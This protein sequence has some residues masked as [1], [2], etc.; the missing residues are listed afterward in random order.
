MAT[1]VDQASNGTPFF[2]IFN[3]SWS[4]PSAITTALAGGLVF[5]SYDSNSNIFLAL[6]QDTSGNPIF[7]TYNGAWTTPTEIPGSSP[8]TNVI[9]SAFDNN[10][11]IFLATWQDEATLKPFYATYNY[12]TD[13]WSTP[14]PID[15]AQGN[16]ATICS[17]DPVNAKFLAAWQ[18]QSLNIHYGIYDYPSNTW[19]RP[20]TK[21]PATIPGSGMTSS[22]EVAIFNSC[23]TATGRF[24]LGWQDASHFPFYDTYSL[25]APAPTTTTV[26]SEPNPSKI[27]ERVNFRAK[28]TSPSLSTPTGKVTFKG[29]GKVLGT[30]LLDSNGVAKL[31]T[32][33]LNHG[34][35]TITAIYQG[36]ANFLGSVGTTTQKVK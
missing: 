15:N 35:F 21:P 5:P 13:T 12:A 22:P 19:R 36:N 7:A 29:G 8:S 2:A 34:T 23:D 11:N 17:F 24:L 3:G 32:C 6:W 25:T 14:G 27:R 31:T 9:F 1:W 28:V 33:A 10:S 20:V 16:F 30:A 26:T 18:D 4:A